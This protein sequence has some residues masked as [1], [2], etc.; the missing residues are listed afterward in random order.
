[1]IFALSLLAVLGLAALLLLLTIWV[2][3]L[4]L[5]VDARIVGRRV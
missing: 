4:A 3:I 1:M 5:W 2:P